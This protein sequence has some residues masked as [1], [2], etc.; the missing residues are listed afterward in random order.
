MNFK[1]TLSIF[2]KIFF[3]IRYQMYND[4]TET[5]LMKIIYDFRR[6][7]CCVHFDTI[8]SSANKKKIVYRQLISE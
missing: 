5:N 7:E 4:I 1:L 8:S 6:T 2:V 3:N